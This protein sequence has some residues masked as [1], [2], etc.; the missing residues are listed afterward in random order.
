MNE[1]VSIVI[2]T[3]NSEVFLSNTID[4]VLAQSYSKLELILI[5]DDSSDSTRKIMEEYKNY[6]TRV[7][8]FFQQ[9][10]HGAGAARNKGILAAK[11]KYL[12]FV[13]SDDY[14]HKDKLKNQIDF[15]IKNNYPF[16]YTK[17]A[18]VD[19]SDNLLKKYNIAPNRCNY[20]RLLLQNCIGCSTVI[21]DMDELGKEYMPGL[22]NRQDWGLWLKYIRKSGKAY[23]MRESYTYYRVLH[24]SISS[25]KVKLFKYH[26]QIY[27]EEEKYNLL[28]SLLLFGI[29][30]LFIV[31]YTTRNKL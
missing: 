24:G 3:Y 21:V 13:D 5:D 28:L 2:P 8:L 6:D 26:W 22:R 18:Y 23:G 10:N 19:E 16:T 14:W 11:G 20:F 15:M 4:S 12:A 9:T 1:L 7:K 30:M 25:K 31:F 29:N 17:Y 27:R